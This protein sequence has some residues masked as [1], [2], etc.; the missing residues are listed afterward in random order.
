MEQQHFKV[1]FSVGTKLLISVLVLLAVVIAFLNISAIFLL[2]EDKRAYTYQS[3]S[4]EVVLAGR[5]FVTTVRHELDTLRIALASIDPSRPVTSQQKSAL[6]TLVDNQSDLLGVSVGLLSP[7][8]GSF[9]QLARAT[10]GAQLKALQLDEK[11]LDLSLEKSKGVTSQLTRDSYAFINASRMDGT[12][13]LGV[14]VADVKMLGNSTGIPVVYGITSLK[15]FGGEIS[16]L[17][18]TIATK[19]G[20]ILFDTDSAVLYSGSNLGE[21]PLFRAALGS[22]LSSGAHEYDDAI[23]GKHYIAS[24]AQPGLNLIVFS[25]ADWKKAIRATYELVIKFALLGLMAIGVALVFAIVFSKTLTRPINR[26]YEATK[27]VA[28]GNF[29]LNLAVKGHDEISALTGSFNVMSTQISELIQAQ[30]DAIHLENEMAIASTVQQTLIPPAEFRNEDIHIHSRYQSASQ[31][32]GDWWGFFGVGKKL[33]VMIADATGHGMP[34]ALITASARSCFSVMHKLAQEDPEFS[35]SPAAM[36]AYANR[37]VYDASM[38]Q[39]MMTFFV[40][41]ID[42]ETL[43]LSYASAGHNPPWLFS[44]DGD[45]FTLHSLTAQGMRLGEGREAPA[46]EEETVDFSPG[47]MLFLYTDGLMEGKDLQGEMYGKKRTRKM[48]E[49][50]LAGGPQAVIEKLMT[51]FLKYNE[52]KDLDD[53]VTLATCVFLENP[54]NGLKRRAQGFVVVPPVVEQEESSASLVAIEAAPTTEFTAS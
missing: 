25:K 40:G 51:D 19:A 39:I 13:T 1:S 20:S 11:D 12:P 4:T 26:L 52:G 45:R 29:N 34:S 23:S 2:R 32:G 35:F 36:L 17:N 15:E 31:C 18:L 5:Q 41:V 3:Q 21:D 22:K 7:Q 6:Q 38:G 54:E 10:R 43:T 47:D 37:V 42:F 53:D 33:C 8:T 9:T 49:A 46:F 50:N 16:G 24:Y 28:K 48:V 44:K 30:A 27:E 14:F